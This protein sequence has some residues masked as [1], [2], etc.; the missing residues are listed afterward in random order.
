M[1][2]N[3]RSAATL[4]ASKNSKNTMS[5]ERIMKRK[6]FSLGIRQKSMPV[7]IDTEFIRIIPKHLRK[8]IKSAESIKNKHI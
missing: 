2:H 8:R 6:Q 7:Q 3:T 5:N 4:T 1:T